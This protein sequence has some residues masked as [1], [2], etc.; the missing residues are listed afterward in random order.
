MNILICIDDI[1]NLESRGTGELASILLNKIENRGWGLC[2][3]VTRHQML[4][5]PEIPYTSHNSAMCFV[6][7]IKTEFLVPLTLFSQTFLEQESAPESDPGLCIVNLE[8][9][10]DPEALMDFGQRA[11]TEVI[12]KQNAYD[13]A[14]RLSIKTGY[15]KN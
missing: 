4:V 10:T 15:G 2:Q 7:N 6:A 8:Q 1:D 11:K 5:H 13:L 9:L 3:P 14:N 12:P